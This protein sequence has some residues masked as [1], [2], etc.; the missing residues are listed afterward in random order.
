MEASSS[1]KPEVSSAV[2]KR[3]ETRSLTDLSFLS[4]VLGSHNA[5]RGRHEPVG[6]DDLLDAVR[7]HLLDHGAALL[8]LGLVLLVLGELEPLLGDGD[9]LLAVVLLEL[10]HA[11]L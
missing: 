4:A 6:H 7:E 8:V 5:A 11:V 9:E 1:V 2:S 3:S 10:L